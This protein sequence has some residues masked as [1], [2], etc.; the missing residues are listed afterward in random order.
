MLEDSL[1]G[2]LACLFKVCIILVYNSLQ[3][4]TDF[5]Q[6]AFNMRCFGNTAGESVNDGQN[7]IPQQMIFM[8]QDK[9]HYE[10]LRLNNHFKITREVYDSILNDDEKSVVHNIIEN[11]HENKTDCTNFIGNLASDLMPT[12]SPPRDW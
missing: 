3:N 7:E 9:K 1:L 8:F 6:Q 4:T 10:S 11:T 5:Y 12:L 2:D